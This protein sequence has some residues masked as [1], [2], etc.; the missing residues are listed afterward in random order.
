M[1]DWRSRKGKME[2]VELIK[3]LVSVSAPIVGAL[4][5]VSAPIVGA[6]IGAIVAVAAIWAKEMLEAR[7]TIQNWFE[8]TYITEGVDPLLALLPIFSA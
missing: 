4:I 6:V 5:S 7:K 3:A 8:Q 2:R 1:F